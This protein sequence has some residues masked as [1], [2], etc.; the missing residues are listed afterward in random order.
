MAQLNLDTTFAME[1]AADDVELYKELLDI[2]KQACLADIR[3]IEQGLQDRNPNLVY[4]AAHSMKGAAASL[5]VAAIHEIALI[6]EQDAKNGSLAVAELS[7][8][9]LSELIEELQKL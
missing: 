4:T 6:I 9:G 1:Q 3:G 7:Y 8:K 2:F 5:G